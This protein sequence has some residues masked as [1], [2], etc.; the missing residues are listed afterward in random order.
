[1][2]EIEK[3]M[4]LKIF[5]FPQKGSMRLKDAGAYGRTSLFLL[6]LINLQSHRS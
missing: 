1:M 2:T 6:L 4:Q 5:F 3:R